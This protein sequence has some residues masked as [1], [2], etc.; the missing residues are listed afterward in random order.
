MELSN[1]SPRWYPPEPE[2]KA[3]AVELVIATIKET[4]E[5]RGVISR[6]ARQFDGGTQSLSNWVRELRST[7]GSVRDSRQPSAIASDSS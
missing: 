1:G 4:G 5:R 3:R 2:V 7:A 6:I